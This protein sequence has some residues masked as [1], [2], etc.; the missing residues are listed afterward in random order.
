[1]WATS[2]WHFGKC[3]KTYDAIISLRLSS[4]SCR[5]V[6]QCQFVWYFGCNID[7]PIIVFILKRFNCKVV[8]IIFG[9]VIRRGFNRKIKPRY[10]CHK[11]PSQITKVFNV[12]GSLLVRFIPPSNLKVSPA[13]RTPWMN[14][15]LYS[16]L[17]CPCRILYLLYPSEFGP[18]AYE[19]IHDVKLTQRNTPR[20]VT[21]ILC[22]RLSVIHWPRVCE[23][24]TK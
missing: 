19:S 12:K 3:Q 16:R 21:R 15:I 20:I 11:F 2:Q 1:M 6:L 24:E 14:Q 4:T 23:V 13:Q 7:I 9:R 8:K 10:R 18:L 22:L 17:F 5:H